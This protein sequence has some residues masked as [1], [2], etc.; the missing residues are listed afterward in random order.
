MKLKNLKLCH[1][2]VIKLKTINEKKDYIQLHAVSLLYSYRRILLSWATGCGKTLGS[3]KM[4]NEI[5][6]HRPNYRGYI[7]CK[8]TG[9][10]NNWND[11]IIKHGMDNIKD[12]SEMF[13]YAS[14]HKYS[15]KGYVDY[16]ILDE[17]H[18][19]TDNRIEHL[20]EIIGPETIVIM[21]SATVD[22]VKS[23]LLRNLCGSYY[24]FHISIS[25]AIGMGLLPSPEVYIH[26]FTLN[27]KEQSEYNNI[28]LEME[29]AKNKHLALEEEWTKIKWIGLGS[30]RKRM[31]AEMKTNR[32]KILLKTTF[33]G[34]RYICFSGSKEQAQKLSPHNFIHSGKSKKRNL[35]KKDSFNAGKINNL[36]VVNMFREAMNLNNIEMGLI[37]QLDNVKLSFIQMLGRVFRSDF[38]EMHIMVLKDTQDEKYLK[39]VLEGFNKQYINIINH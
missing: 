10:L 7:I 8:E 14:L 32:A 2:D 34:K 33:K 6:S 16:I 13:L 28:N 35:N 23:D 11:D 3:L 24:E 25:D 37:V 39:R 29:R 17:C 26:Y 22:H 20:S 36:V 1:D 31:M 5:L 21:L 27:S 18:A 9:H 15:K 38:P 12:N 19:V 30:K 4:V